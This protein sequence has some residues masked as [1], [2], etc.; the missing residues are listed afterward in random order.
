VSSLRP[1]PT[2]SHHQQSQFLYAPWACTSH[3]S[4]V[5]QNSSNREQVQ[6]RSNRGTLLSFPPRLKHQPPALATP[7][8]ASNDFLFSVVTA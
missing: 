7:C 1:A 6:A 4:I 5:V 8:T 3:S 2:R